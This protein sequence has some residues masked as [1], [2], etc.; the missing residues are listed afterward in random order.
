[1]TAID[2][3]AATTSGARRRRVEH[4]L[5]LAEGE[6]H[7]RE[8]ADLRERD[9]DEQPLVR[10]E[11][12]RAAEREEEAQLHGHDT[13]DEPG[14]QE[15][16][17]AHVPEVDGR[18]DG[19]EEEPE[20]EPAERLDVALQLVAVLARGEHHAGEE[21]PERGGEPDAGHEERDPDDEQ[22]RGRGEQLAEPRA[23]DGAERG[24][25]ERAP[26]DDDRRDG[27]E[28]RERLRP[29]RQPAHPRLRGRVPGAARRVPA[30]GAG[31]EHG[32]QGEHRDDGDVLEEEHRER[33]LP[34]R[35]LE[36]P[37]LLER[38]ED[39]GGRGQRQR[40]AG[41]ERR[42]PREPEEAREPGER[43]AREEHLQPSEPEDR[44]AQAPQPRR[45]E[46]EPDDEQHEHDPELGDVHH[47]LAVRRGGARA[48]PPAAPPSSPRPNGPMAAPASR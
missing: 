22:Q 17:V 11:A 43:E 1:V 18:A 20:E 15:R 16:R 48:A 25:H 28:D 40:H 5:L 2:S 36:E 12:E 41:A 13:E 19:E 32:E 24:A 29:P 27:A 10:P 21:R 45:L 23:R 37:A 26:A 34:A 33:A 42:R 39:D 44:A 6:E 47:R 8:L 35:A 4:P 3:A 31:A 7:E 9:G 46:L 30:G 38:L 14:D